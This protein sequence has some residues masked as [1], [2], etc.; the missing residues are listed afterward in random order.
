ML[1]CISY[2]LGRSALRRIPHAG[3]EAVQAMTGGPGLIAEMRQCI[4]NDEQRAQ[5][6]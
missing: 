4:L 2:Q 3:D 5:P 6:C 1:F